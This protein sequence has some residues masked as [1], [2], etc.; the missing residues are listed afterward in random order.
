MK[1]TKEK[2]ESVVSS[3]IGEG[4]VIFLDGTSTLRKCGAMD[5]LVNH[6]GYIFGGARPQKERNIK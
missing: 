1:W 3:N 4:K 5:Y 2:A 6:C